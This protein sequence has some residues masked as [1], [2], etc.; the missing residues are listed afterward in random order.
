MRFNKPLKLAII[1]GLTGLMII[2]VLLFLE[3]KSISVASDNQQL[4][5]LN[6]NSGLYTFYALAIFIIGVIFT[7]FSIMAYRI[8]KKKMEVTDALILS[9]KRF[10]TIFEEAPLGIALVEADTG[11]INDANPKYLEILGIKLNELG[12]RNWMSLTHPDN[13]QESLLYKEKINLNTLKNFKLKKKYKRPD[14]TVVWGSLSVSAIDTRKQTH[15]LYLC[16]L[17]DITEQRNVEEKIKEV[18]DRYRS[19]VDNATDIII[20]VD[21]EDRITFINYAAGGYTREQIIGA[22]VYDFVSEEYHELVKETHDAVRKKKT[23]R[24]YETISVGQD[25][26]SRWFLTNVSPVLND[27]EVVGLTLFTKDISSRKQTEEALRAS[28]NELRKIFSVMEEVIFELD[29]DGK[30]L[31]VAPTNP[32]LLYKSAEFLMGKTINDVFP[33]EEARFFIEQLRLCLDK[34]KPVHVEYNLTINGKNIVFEAS[35]LPLTALT[36]LWVARDITWRKEVEKERTKTQIDFEDAQRLAKI[37]SWELNLS[38]FEVKWSKEMYRIFEFE[39]PFPGKLYDAYKSVC[40]SNSLDVINLLLKNAMEKGQGFHNEHRITCKSGT[41]KYLS[42]I[43][44]V[45]KDVTGKVIAVKGTEQDITEMKQIQDLL[46]EKEQNDSL[47][48]YAAQ[49][50]GAMYQFRFFPDG[51]F[52]FPFVSD[53]ATELCGLTIE[54]IKKDAVKVFSLVLEE[55]FNSLIASIHRSKDQL[56][57]WTQEFRIRHLTKGVRWIRGNSRPEMLE[58]G[59]VLWH[60]YFNDTTDFK[61]AEESLKIS[62]D[63]LEAV[64]NGSND[65][66]MLLTRKGFFD[67]NPKTL[68]M[69]GLTD[70]SEFIA[71]HPSDLSP[72]L[73]PDGQSSVTKSKEMIELAFEKGFK[74]FEW[75]HK[76]KSG[77]VFPAEVLL[78]AFGYGEEVVL[79]ATVHD[80]TERKNAERKLKQNEA[81]LSSILQTLPVAV[82]GKNI[83]ENFRFSIWNKKAEEI[84]GLKSEDCIGKTDYD[85]FPKEDADWYRKKDMEAS[86]INGILDIPEEVVMNKDKRVIVHTKKIVVR[87]LHGN[88]HFLLGVSEDITEQKEVEEKIRKSEEKYRSV[89]KNAVDIIIIIDDKS[90]IQ[91]INHSTTTQNIIGKSIY[92]FILPDYADLVKQKLKKVY[93]T[94][95]PQSYE[96]KGTSGGTTAWYSTNAGPIFSGNEVVGITLIV[97]NITERKAAEEKTRLSLKEKEILLKEVHHRVKN[98]LQII[99]SILN[100]Q[101]ANISDTKTLELLRDVRSRIKAMSFIHEL[102]YQA[103]DFSNINFSEYISNISTNLIYSYTQKEI[104]LKLDVGSVFLDLD[105]AIPCGLIVNELLTNALKYAFSDQEEGE[106][107]ISLKQT[108]DFIQLVVADN[109]KGFP[110]T[111]DY[112]NTESLGMQLVMTLVQQLRGEI[113][114]DNSNGAKYTIVFSSNSAS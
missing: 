28:E 57:Y 4:T 60:G 13:M 8:L 32:A 70:R 26:V 42:C 37:G 78:S 112:R 114:L 31:K 75:M 97:R 56:E 62:K 109:G 49:L 106:V 111:I 20:T 29:R 53:G 52:F 27:E 83:K 18:Q 101:Y 96:I 82:F 47:I 22:N 16:L 43:G 40:D 99:L 36:V 69:F 92:E 105:R 17:E 63:R 14:G 6:A 34:N 68:E 33:E 1:I 88:P 94:K 50:P 77:E 41:V 107:F 108:P 74:R 98:N 7:F 3:Y 90:N 11:I 91:F 72:I 64:F 19:L 80:I 35:L 104:E 85:F 59:S 65:A 2:G 46:K 23:S 38:T 5:V 93:E 79:Q 25:G 103:N 39:Y 86:R 24:T 95:Q 67:C 102:L 113:T 100:L 45:V 73:Q 12:K 15:P 76:R 89:V 10:R 54:E 9:E 81:L 84:F 55:D 87:D 66:I 51:H 44:E 30:Y 58:D 71:R 48:R 21:L 110:S 61:L